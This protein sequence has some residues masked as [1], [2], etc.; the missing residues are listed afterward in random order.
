MIVKFYEISNDFLNKL[1]I[2]KQIHKILENSSRKFKDSGKYNRFQ[3]INKIRKKLIEFQ[4]QIKQFQNRSIRDPTEGKF[5]NQ[6]RKR[7]MNKK[8]EISF[9]AYLFNPFSFPRSME[10]DSPLL[11]FSLLKLKIK[12]GSRFTFQI[13]I[14]VHTESIQIF[15]HT[16]YPRNLNRYRYQFAHG[17]V[18]EINIILIDSRISSFPSIRYPPYSILSSFLC[19]HLLKIIKKYIN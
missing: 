11:V 18:P 6:E 8:H 13:Y 9:L 19:W 7:K 1:E 4:K 12:L 15:S 17:F 14:Q 3:R 2:P 16:F 5:N 10:K